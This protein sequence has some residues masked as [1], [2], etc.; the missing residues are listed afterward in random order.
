MRHEPRRSIGAKYEYSFPYYNGYYRPQA[1]GSGT[2]EWGARLPLG[3]FGPHP[4]GIARPDI[5]IGIET[6]GDKKFYGIDASFG[7]RLI[8]GLDLSFKIGITR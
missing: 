3:E 5:G 4:K 2:H 1:S 8:L 6:R 7:A